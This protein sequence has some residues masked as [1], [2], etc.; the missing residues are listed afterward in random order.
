VPKLATRAPVCP[1]GTV[2]GL[3]PTQLYPVHPVKTYPGAGVAVNVTLGPVGKLA[4]QVAPQ[5]MPAGLETT[6]PPAASNFRTVRV[7]DAPRVAG[8]EIDAS[9]IED[10]AKIPANLHRNRR[11]LMAENR[12]TLA[13][14]LMLLYPRNW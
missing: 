7:T 13:S 14:S 1:I 11:L 5:S 9:A 12:N 2:Q 8:G 6:F 3:V 4:L 10:S